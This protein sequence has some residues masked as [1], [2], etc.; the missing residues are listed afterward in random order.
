MLI[1]TLTQDDVASY[2]VLRREMLDDAPWAFTASPGDDVGC[3]PVKLAARLLEPGQA[4]VGAF[5]TSGRIVGAAG[6]AR[7]PRKKLSH[8]VLIWGVYVTPSARGLGIARDV[9]TR[10]IE[11]ARS[12]PGVT[13]LALAASERAEVAI[14]LYQRLGFKAWGTEPAA[15]QIGG[16]TYSEIHMVAFLDNP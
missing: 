2:C 13:S 6:L 1:R 11:L 8:R 5:D 4:I 12:W 3:D 7:N 9:L 10:S 16:Q 15:V 14:R